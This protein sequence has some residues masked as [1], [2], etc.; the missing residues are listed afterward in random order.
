MPLS[1]LVAEGLSSVQAGGA[2]PGAQGAAPP[3]PAGRP[4]DSARGQASASGRRDP[5]EAGQGSRQP[6]QLLPALRL[7]LVQRRLQAGL[8]APQRP[9]RLGSPQAQAPRPPGL[10][11]HQP[12][13][14]VGLGARTSLPG[15]AQGGQLPAH[16]LPRGLLCGLPRGA[17][18]RPLAFDLQRET[19]VTP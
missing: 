8:P 3:G 13:G 2:G 18:L 17:P 19:P 14:P 4:V 11:P 16:G 12:E 5:E 6:G 15:L 10:S 7:E 1:L 9:D